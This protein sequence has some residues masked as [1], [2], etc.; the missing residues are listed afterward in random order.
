MTPAPLDAK[1]SAQVALD[2]LDDQIEQ[3]IDSIVALQK[4]EWENAGPTQ[5]LIAIV[6]RWMSKPAYLIVLVS[7]IVM[8]LAAN[9]GATLLGFAAWDRS[10]FAI[11]DSVMTL[12]GL[13]TG[14]VVLVAQHR[15][16]RLEQ[17]HSQLTLQIGLLT[18]QKTT[19]IIHLIEELR[20]DMPM[21]RDR[22]DAHAAAL[23]E[24]P[25]AEQLISVLKERAGNE[26]PDEE[27]V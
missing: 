2:S 1:S 27:P 19:K 21:V 24:S 4:Q 10:P 15:Q 6:S 9:I 13:V 11:L 8:W 12:V 22:H 20:R 3:N 18:E 25:D 23:Q 14:T 7:L 5:R 26:S 16:G 17:Q